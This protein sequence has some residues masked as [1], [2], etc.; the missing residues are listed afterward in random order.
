M[1]EIRWVSLE[2]GGNKT[3]EMVGWNGMK[4]PPSSGAVFWMFPVFTQRCWPPQRT[5]DPKYTW[6]H[7]VQKT[8][9][10]L[11]LAMLLFCIQKVRLVKIYDLV[12]VFSLVFSRLV[13]PCFHPVLDTSDVWYSCL[14]LSKLRGTHLVVIPLLH[15]L[16]CPLKTFS[17]CFCR[18]MIIP[19]SY[20]VEHSYNVKTKQNWDGADLV[21]FFQASFWCWSLLWMPHSKD[22]YASDLEADSSL[23]AQCRNAKQSS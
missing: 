16:Y 15:C 17:K 4:I 13:S 9:R 11:S 14:G 18:S 8:R 10:V 21:Q 12:I 22:L 3:Q 6:N 2:Q 5:R 1:L 7:M 23:A 20:R 19:D